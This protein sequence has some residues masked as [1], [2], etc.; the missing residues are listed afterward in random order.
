[1]RRCNAHFYF[2]HGV[3]APGMSKLRQASL[4][5]KKRVDSTCVAV[6]PLKVMSPPL[7]IV[8][9]QMKGKSCFACVAPRERNRTW[10]R[11]S[12]GKIPVN[13]RNAPDSAVESPI[14]L[15]A[16]GML[17]GERICQKYAT[18]RVAAW[19]DHIWV[20]FSLFKCV[21]YDVT[22]T[23]SAVYHPVSILACDR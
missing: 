19:T 20:R 5:K 18:T 3:P 2:Q 15:N 1:M 17:L 22:C 13:K 21:N 16:S 10:S 23:C 14:F 7:S 9:C 11:D 12:M 4:R 6:G 8:G